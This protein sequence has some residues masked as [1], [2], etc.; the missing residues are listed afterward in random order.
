MLVVLVTHNVQFIKNLSRTLFCDARLT[1][2]GV[3]LIPAHKIILATFSSKFKRMFESQDERDVL[4]I[5]PV[6]DFPNL[7]RVINFIYDSRITLHSKAEF[8]DFLDALSILKVEVPHTV[9][10]MKPSWRGELEVVDVKHYGAEGEIGESLCS[11]QESSEQ[12]SSQERWELEALRQKALSSLVEVESRTCRSAS[13]LER[14]GR[15]S[16]GRQG[17]ESSP[18]RRSRGRKTGRGFDG[19]EN[20]D[21]SKN[22]ESGS[23]CERGE[24]W[25]R[26]SANDFHIKK[27]SSES[28]GHFVTSRRDAIPEGDLRLK[29]SKRKRDEKSSPHRDLRHKIKKQQSEKCCSFSEEGNCNCRRVSHGWVGGEHLG[30]TPSN[31]ERLRM[32]GG[33]SIY[34]RDKT[35]TVE[36]LDLEEHFSK[37][38]DVVKVKFVG[39]QGGS[40][41]F[42]VVVTS[43][44][45]SNQM[46]SFYNIR[47]V[48]LEVESKI[49]RDNSCLKKFELR[50]EGSHGRGK[51]GWWKTHFVKLRDTRAAEEVKEANAVEKEDPAIA[52]CTRGTPSRGEISQL[53]SSA[54]Q[55][56]SNSANIAEDLREPQGGLYFNLPEAVPATAVSESSVESFLKGCRNRVE[57]KDEKRD[58]LLKVEKESKEA[59]VKVKEEGDHKA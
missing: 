29:L 50:S 14:L 40:N 45:Q 4:T 43:S 8:D 7:K 58:L 1:K 36:T 18:M 38:R 6:V 3:A 20:E 27:T 11:E 48:E 44:W 30:R 47:G 55:Q 5:V 53:F 37:D 24:K 28:A 35:C 41:I 12:D 32:V 56:H 34:L 49:Q 19:S 46:R 26:E 33:E 21:W 10:T 52:S 51:G 16:I 17:R 54:Q 42:K 59:D 9:T 39:K 23:G 2:D 15:S 31:P 57:M 25:N 13:K 22:V